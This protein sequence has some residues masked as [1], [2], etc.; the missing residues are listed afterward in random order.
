MDGNDLGCFDVVLGAI[1]VFGKA[2]YV[3]FGKLLEVFLGYKIYCYLLLPIFLC[4]FVLILLTVFSWFIV[5]HNLRM[6]CSGWWLDGGVQ[7]FILVHVV[8]DRLV[9]TAWSGPSNSITPSCHS[10]VHP[11]RTNWPNWFLNIIHLL[12][13]IFYDLVIILNPVLKFT[14]LILQLIDLL[15]L[16]LQIDLIQIMLPHRLGRLLFDFVYLIPE[17]IDLFFLILNRSASLFKLLLLLFDLSAE[18]FYDTIAFGDF[19]GAELQFFFQLLN[20]LF[21]RFNC[22]LK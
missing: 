5:A 3:G 21:L 18:F 8:R 2:G 9:V 1:E 11:V 22:I 14:N 6:L 17:L 20:C 10:T 16:L 12:I 19:F 7:F 4:E 15:S 13:Q